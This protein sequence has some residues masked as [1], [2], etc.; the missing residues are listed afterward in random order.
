MAIIDIVK[1][2]AQEDEFIWKFPSE[3]LRIGTQ[4]IVNPSQHAIFIKGGKILDEFNHTLNLFPLLF[5]ILSDSLSFA[6]QKKF[7]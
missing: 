7:Q 3:D 4:V 2:Q 5:D 6:V 1:Y